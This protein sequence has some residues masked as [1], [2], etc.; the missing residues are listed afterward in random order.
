[1]VLLTVLFFIVALLYAMA[2]FGGGS[3]YVAVLT[4]FDVP[5]TELPVVALTC[6]VIVVTGGSI[7]FISAGHARWRLIFP[8]VIAGVPAAFLGG[9]YPI[10][11]GP[12]TLLLAGCLLGVGIQMAWQWR[13][14]G[15]AADELYGRL[16]WTRGLPIGAALGAM[17]G[18]AGIGG[19]VVLASVLNVLRWGT[20]REVAAAS[21]VFVLLS[22]LAGLGGQLHKHGAPAE[23]WAAYIPVFAAVLVGGQAGSYL[24]ARRTTLKQIRLATAVVV[25]VSGLYAL[26]RF[27]T[28]S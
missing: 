4:L 13:A 19:G 14:T 17:S 24:G 21:S 9:V 20:S 16:L 22:S 26:A 18:M 5:H 11:E 23:F 2:G 27:L 28:L 7:Q 8:F 15:R 10:R 25:A 12:F 6:N 1:M 3:S